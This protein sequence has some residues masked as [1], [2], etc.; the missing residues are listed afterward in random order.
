MNDAISDPAPAVL[1][2]IAPGLLASS[3]PGS[4]PLRLVSAAMD[5]PV[6][7]IVEVGVY[8]G[9]SAHW[10]EKVAAHRGVALW[11]YDTFTGIPCKGSYDSHNVGDF[12]DTSES[13]V[14]CRFS[15]AHVVKGIFPQS[16]QDNAPTGISFAHLDVDQEQSYREAIAFLRPRM[17]PRGIMWFDD[18]HLEGA[19]R[20]IK[21]AF[22]WPSIQTCDGAFN[23]WWVRL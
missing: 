22:P 9:G 13:Y 11:L 21:E 23:K 20:A 4:L 5:T 12:G 16:A 18:A 15:K 17:L 19:R 6:G 3:S 1:E 14:R 7:P 8:R 2:V 10:L